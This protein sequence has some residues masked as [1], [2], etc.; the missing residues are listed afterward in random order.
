MNFLAIDFETTGLF[1]YNLEP[2]PENLFMFPHICQIGLC[3]NSVSFS[4]LVFPT[5]E[6]EMSPDAE[7]IHGHSLEK[8]RQHGL[9]FW[10][11]W[12]IVSGLIYMQEDFGKQFFDGIICH[13]ADFDMTLLKVELMRYEGLLP[14]TPFPVY[15]TQKQSTHIP[16]EGKHGPSLD[17]AARHYQLGRVGRHHDAVEDARL[18]LNIFKNAYLEGHGNF[19][20]PYMTFS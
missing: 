12:K 15:C 18:C 4:S 16:G 7:M 9:D 14:T 20:A 5:G 2:T 8:C 6:W 3:S 10:D 1:P 11:L 19:D 13:N 17:E